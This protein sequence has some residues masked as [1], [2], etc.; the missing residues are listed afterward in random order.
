M[1][2]NAALWL[3]GKI[4]S[5]L[6][7]MTK[8]LWLNM[9]PHRQ[10]IVNSPLVSAVNHSKRWVIQPMDRCYRDFVDIVAAEPVSFATPQLDADWS[11][12]CAW[13]HPLDKSRQEAERADG[14]VNQNTYCLS[15][16]ISL[17]DSF[18]KH[19]IVQFS[20]KCRFSNAWPC[21]HPPLR[22]RT[23]LR[24]TSPSPVI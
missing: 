18:I 2:A 5:L 16:R 20:G 1:C 11:V 10:N 22:K 15:C 12:R 7:L 8:W 14:G 6:T 24:V 21:C 13:R 9:K 4:T 19:R 17:S 3:A 23:R